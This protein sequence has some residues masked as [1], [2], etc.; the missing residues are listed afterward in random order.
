[1]SYVAG[2]GLFVDLDGMTVEQRLAT[3]A[4]AGISRRP[5]GRQPVDLP[6]IPQ[7]IW[8]PALMFPFGPP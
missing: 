2:E 4:A 7:T 1:M 6:A 3:G 8:R 5:I